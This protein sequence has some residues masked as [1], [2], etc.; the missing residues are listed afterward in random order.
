MAGNRRHHH[1]TSH[2]NTNHLYCIY[3]IPGS[4]YIVSFHPPRSIILYQLSYSSMKSGLLFA[5]AAFAGLANCDVH[6]L[7]LEKVPLSEQL[8]HADITR[9][10]N[11]LY[12]KYSGQRFMGIRPEAQKEEMFKDTS[13]HLDQAHPVPVS[14]FL[15]AQCWQHHIL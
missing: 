12:K 2:N 1:P 8:E 3:Q 10:A 4:I 14:N 5:A 11:S 15:N 6:R 7:K 13:V 9:H